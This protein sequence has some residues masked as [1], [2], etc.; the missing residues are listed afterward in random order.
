MAYFPDNGRV[1]PAVLASL[2]RHLNKLY[3]TALDA[4]DDVRRQRTSIADHWKGKASQSWRVE[5]A[6][7]RRR[8]RAVALSAHESKAYV[9]R[10]RAVV[11][12]RN[13]AIDRARA[14]FDRCRD[15]LRAIYSRFSGLDQEAFEVAYA[16]A[17]EDIEYWEGLMR[18]MSGVAEDAYSEMVQAYV[19][20]RG[21]LDSAALLLDPDY[22]RKLG[23]FGAVRGIAGLGKRTPSLDD[24]ARQWGW[25]LESVEGLPADERARLADSYWDSLSDDEKQYLAVEE[26]VGNRQDTPYSVRYKANAIA[27]EYE[28]DVGL[29]ERRAELMRQIEELEEK[30]RGFPA[31]PGYRPHE[32]ELARL[33]A[34]YARLN[35]DD[36]ENLL[37][38]RCEPGTEPHVL[39]FDPDSLPDHGIADVYGDLES[40]LNVVV[41]VPGTGN[42]GT[43]FGGF[44]ESARDLGGGGEHTAV[45]AWLDYDAP[46]DIPD[47]FQFADEARSMSE[48]SMG[49]LVEGL[50]EKSVTLVGHSAGSTAVQHFVAHSPSAEHVDQVVLFAAPNLNA[51]FVDVVA[52]DRSISVEIYFHADDQGIMTSFEVQGGGDL[53]DR[54]YSGVWPTGE[55]P[56]GDWRIVVGGTGGHGFDGYVAD[57]GEQVQAAA[58]TPNTIESLDGET[59]HRQTITHEDGTQETVY[60]SGF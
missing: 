51:D 39:F 10:F 27:I 20:L 56:S 43:T 29:P 50:S 1:D 57:F 59:M 46:A 36:Y 40:A 4:G 25:F 5:A 7:L 19:R 31:E 21:D 9:A 48:S 44:S 54:H 55:L 49:E 18:A 28:L 6:D 47:N 42:D 8:V 32:A 17:R 37:R 15:E 52:N 53:L 23:G 16:A 26:R 12:D 11:E 41:A 60:L 13:A 35:S 3:K 33:R 22:V 58:A 24:V 14:K 30:V 38:A 34:E 2:E 45:I